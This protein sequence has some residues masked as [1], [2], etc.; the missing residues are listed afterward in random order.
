MSSSINTETSPYLP[1]FECFRATA[2]LPNLTNLLADSRSSTV[3]PR[4]RSTA[5]GSED[6]FK[7]ASKSSTITTLRFENFSTFLFLEIHMC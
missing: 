3:K 2:F 7:S 4:D 1:G 6:F 5:S